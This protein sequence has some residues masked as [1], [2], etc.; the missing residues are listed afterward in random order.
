MSHLEIA[1]EL[2]RNK[3]V[4]E[5]LLQNT[6][7]D[8]YLWRPQPEKWS[9]L[10]IICHLYDEEREDFRARVM[11]VLETPH[12]PMPPIDPMGWVARRKYMEQDY[13]RVLE[14]FLAERE[15]SV[16]Y[17]MSLSGVGWQNV[18]VHPKLGPMT[19][20]LLIENWLAHDLLHIRQTT[21]VKYAYLKAHADTPLNYAG[22]W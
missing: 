4:F 3:R 12:M 16:A 6:A 20:D 10:E 1:K 11:H 19:A 17:L 22:D 13:D 14:H 7:A 2:D 9:L 5:Q 8:Q 21:A 15:H 18:Y